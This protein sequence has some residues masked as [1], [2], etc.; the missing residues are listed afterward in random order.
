M[1]LFTPARLATSLPS[2]L[3]CHSLSSFSYPFHSSSSCSTFSRYLPSSSSTPALRSSFLPSFS[4]QL[5]ASLIVEIAIKKYAPFY[6]SQSSPEHIIGAQS[7]RFVSKFA[8]LRT[9]HRNRCRRFSF[10]P[11]P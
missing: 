6:F 8:A 9:G 7:A 10:S 11:A 1:V 5:L 3:L 2:G 4:R